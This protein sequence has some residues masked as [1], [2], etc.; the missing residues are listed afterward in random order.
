[1]HQLVGKGQLALANEFLHEI[2]FVDY[3][4]TEF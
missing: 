3:L 2:G 1:M 4:K